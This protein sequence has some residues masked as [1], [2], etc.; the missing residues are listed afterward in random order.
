VKFLGI[1]KWIF[2]IYSKNDNILLSPN[3][4]YDQ[5]TKSILKLLKKDSPFIFDREINVLRS[6]YRDTGHFLEY[7]IGECEYGFY[8]NLIDELLS[9]K[10]NLNFI[11]DN[12]LWNK[13]IDKLTKY[14][15]IKYIVFCH[16][17]KLL[18]KKNLV[19]LIK[20]LFIL[21]KLLGVRIFN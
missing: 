13:N 8:I 9:E 20:K 15:K 16:Y 1:K 12:D 4:F 5:K 14:I 18:Q 19:V 10:I 3:V 7:F 21:K 2:F 11:L 17:K 6:C